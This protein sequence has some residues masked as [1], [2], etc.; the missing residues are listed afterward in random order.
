[1]WG[2]MLMA[3]PQRLRICPLLLLNLLSEFFVFLLE[4]AVFSG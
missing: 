4:V 3:N 2:F 1:M